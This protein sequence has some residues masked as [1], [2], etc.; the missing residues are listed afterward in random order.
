MPKAIRLVR[1]PLFIFGAGI[2]LVLILLLL[3][4]WFNQPRYTQSVRIGIISDIHK[5]AADTINDYDENLV[6]QFV[7]DVNKLDTDFVI[8][9]GDNASRRTGKCSESADQDLVDV[10]NILSKIKTRLYHVLGDHDIDDADS[11]E[12]WKHVTN[13][14]RTYYSFDVRDVHVV[15]L[16]TITGDGAIHQK[17]A[18]DTLCRRLTKNYERLLVQNSNEQSAEVKNIKRELD[19]RKQVIEN[20]RNIKIR[21]RGTISQDQLNWLSRDLQQTKRVKV[22]IFSEL[23]IFFHTRSDGKIF[24]IRNR[25]KLQE[26]LR[27]SGKTI[28]SV[29]GDAHEW[30]AS[31]EG[32]IDYYVV[33]SFTVSQGEWAYLEWGERDVR[34]VRQVSKLSHEHSESNQQR[35]YFEE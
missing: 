7:D 34:L 24:D 18:K 31:R 35:N 33:G 4:F 3:L 10:I 22:V 26:I 1:Q 27:S 29:S 14:S 30:G 8:D 32:A 5:C 25:N 28:V 11:L 19:E 15:V 9:M 2:L 16:D 17:C 21:N 13:M 6:R 20:S 23:P 12:V